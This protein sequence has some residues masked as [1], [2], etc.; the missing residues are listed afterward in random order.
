MIACLLDS[1]SHFRGEYTESVPDWFGDTDPKSLELF[2]E[3]QRRMT[4]SEKILNV[5]RANE[6]IRALAEADVRRLYPQADDREVFLRVA[7]RHLDPETMRRVY[8]WAPD[9]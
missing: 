2:I 5:F 1:I 4:A 7:S 6:L 9:E 8:N 3:L